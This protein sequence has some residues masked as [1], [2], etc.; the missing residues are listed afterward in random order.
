MPPSGSVFECVHASRGLSVRGRSPVAAVLLLTLL[1]GGL[2]GCGLATGSGRAAPTATMSVAKG[3]PKGAESGVGVT[4][5]VHVLTVGDAGHVTEARVGDV[6]QVRLP[7]AQR[8]K[9]GKDGA[10]TLELLQPAGYWDVKASACVWN[11]RAVKVGATTLSFGGMAICKP[12]Q[13]CA[14]YVVAEEFP[15]TVV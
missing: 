10:G 8:W 15:I 1:A 11:F 14:Q 12:G 9:L 13:P 4:A 7:A 3:C 5:P 2:V 6:V